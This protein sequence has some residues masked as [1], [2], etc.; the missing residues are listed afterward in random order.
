MAVLRKISNATGAL[1]FAASIL[2]AQAP[3]AKPSCDVGE[4]AKGNASKRSAKSKSGSKAGAKSTS[5]SKPAG[6]SKPAAKK[7]R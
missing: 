4:S 6:K 3:A 1:V 7:K 2:G 5:K